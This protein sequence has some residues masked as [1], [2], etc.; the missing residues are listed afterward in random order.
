MKR[1]TMMHIGLCVAFILSCFFLSAGIPPS[2][3]N[4]ADGKNKSELKTALHVIICQDTTG[5]FRHGSG[6]GHTWEAFY[7][8]DRD[9]ETNAVIDMYSSKIRYFPDPNPNFSSFGYEVHIE[10]SMPKSWWGSLT[11]APYKDLHHLYPADGST[12][13]SKSNHPLGVVSGTVS[14]DNGVSKVGYANYDGYSG[15]VFEPA[16]EYKGDFARSYFYMVTA[17]QNYYSL[18]NS[19]MLLKNTYP[20][21]NNWSIELLLSWHHNDAVSE[22]ELKRTE[23][24]YN[25]Q[26]NRNPFI[27]HPELADYI[28]GQN[29]DDLWGQTLSLTDVEF[30]DWK[31]LADPT[32]SKINVRSSTITPINI[33]IYHLNGINI[34]SYSSLTNSDISIPKVAEGIYIVEII[35]DNQLLRE[36]III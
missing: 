9:V 29:V 34:F 27:D 19:P 24:V 26:G 28:W 18:W 10:H 25:P 8:T 15:K 20:T 21:L 22:K 1:F 6:H 12:N 2:Y 16:D 7:Y 23:V 3:Y 4:D 31:L 17:Y 13:I 33:N 14:M 5:Y 32:D 30:N 35:S 11:T 36:K